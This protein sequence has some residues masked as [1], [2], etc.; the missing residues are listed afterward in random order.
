MG[1][2]Y[3]VSIEPII[4]GYVT[5]PFGY[6]LGESRPDSHRIALR[7]RRLRLAAGIQRGYGRWHFPPKRSRNPAYPARVI[8][9]I[10]VSLHSVTLLSRCHILQVAIPC[11]DS[12][13]SIGRR[14]LAI[15]ISQTSLSLIESRA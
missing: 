6:P 3:Y 7:Q 14:A 11:G 2:G 5:I 1:R 12:I 13:P 8:T 10:P 15:G 4:A 9:P